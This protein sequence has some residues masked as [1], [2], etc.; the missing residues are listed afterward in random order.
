MGNLESA[1]RDDSNI[2]PLWR[3]EAHGTVDGLV[4]LRSMND[5]LAL[6]VQSGDHLAAFIAQDWTADNELNRLTVASK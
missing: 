5:G 3:V 1:E 2:D 4:G 6:A